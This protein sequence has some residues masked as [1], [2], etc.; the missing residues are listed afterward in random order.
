M[1]DPRRIVITGLGLVTAVGNDVETTW[2]NLL[3][4]RNGITR[5]TRFDTTRQLVK[6]A[7][8]VK[9]DFDPAQYMDYKM[10]RRSGRFAHFAVAASKQAL[11]MAKLEIN[12]TTRDE[13]G[14]IV[15]SSGGAFEMGKQE[16]VIEERGASK[17]D[18]LLIPRLGAWRPQRVLA[19]CW[20]CAARTRRCIRRA[21]RGRTRWARR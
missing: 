19:G 10:A 11:C 20:A 15:A 18:P 12:D 3:A 1:T 13:I 16:Q 5:I 8:E 6:I 17:V 9:S 7:A 2:Q 21:R 14:V 4:G